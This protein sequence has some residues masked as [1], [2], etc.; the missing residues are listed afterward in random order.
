MTTIGQ[1]NDSGYKL[2]FTEQKKYHFSKHTQNLAL[3]KPE[4]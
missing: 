4:F 2:K 3:D 1:K